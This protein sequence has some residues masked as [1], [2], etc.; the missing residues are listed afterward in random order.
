MRR[1]NYEK[2]S[3]LNSDFHMSIYKKSENNLLISLIVDLWKNANRYDSVFD[4]NDAYIQKSTEEH[5][6]ILKLLKEKDS[7]G[8]QQ[9]VSVHKERVGHEIINLSRKYI[10]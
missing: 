10:D 5:Y 8:V 4:R 9:K 7:L 1:K 6:A 3:E 2:Y